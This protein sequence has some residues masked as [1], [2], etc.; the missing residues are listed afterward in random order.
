MTQKERRS[1]VRID[2]H[3]PFE[4]ELLSMDQY[5]KE[6]EDFKEGVS[7]LEQLELKYPFFS[8]IQDKYKEIEGE[9]DI[10]EQVIL[11]L[12][13]SLNEKLDSLINILVKDTPPDKKNLCFKKSSYINISGAGIRFFSPHKIK[14]GSF[15]KLRICIPLFPSFI[16]PALG[17]VAWTRKEG[18]NYKIGVNFTAIHDDDRDA[19]IHYIFIRQRKRIRKRK[20]KSS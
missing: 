10:G 19:L 18:D 5:E 6:L 3:I 16:I 11:D 9:I 12:L 2:D 7:G 14:E 13:V 1:A 17:K 4:Y 8:W 20:D 15:L